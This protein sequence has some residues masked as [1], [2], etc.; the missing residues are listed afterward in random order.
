[1]NQLEH[2]GDCIKTRDYAVDR[3]IDLDI[4]GIFT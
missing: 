3:L 2:F 1:M 4:K